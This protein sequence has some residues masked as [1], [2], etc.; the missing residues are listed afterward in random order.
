VQV[1]VKPSELPDV[2]ILT[3]KCFDDAR[4]FFSETYNER[5][6][7]ELGIDLRFVQDN[8]SHSAE[9]GTVRGLHYQLPPH[10]QDKLVRVIRGAILDVAVD[11]RVGSPT[12]GR[13]VSTVTSAAEWDQILVP[14]GFAHGYAT[15]EP[16]T[17]VFYKTTDFYAPDF[18]RAIRWNDP[19]IGIE[20]GLA[21]GQAVVSE[22][23][24]QAPLLADAVDLFDGSV[25]GI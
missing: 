9:P 15:L 22:R 24:A 7:Q 3:P 16:D 5:L 21:Q 2:L 14:A 13:H 17:E 18:E 11:I 19:A 23:D 6:W 4:G 8:H 1:N 25:Y 20:W 10:A 12:F